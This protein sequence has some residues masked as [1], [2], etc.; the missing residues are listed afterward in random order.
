MTWPLGVFLTSEPA[1]VARRE[2]SGYS[3][4]NIERALKSLRRIAKISATQ[5][6]AR[7]VER[8]KMRHPLL[9]QLSP[10]D[11]KALAIIESSRR[12]F[13]NEQELSE[14]RRNQRRSSQKQSDRAK[15]PRKRL[16]PEQLE[17][18]QKHHAKWLAD[19]NDSDHGW[20]KHCCCDL[21]LDIDPRTLRNYL[22]H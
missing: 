4:N 19:H 10:S 17:D 5:A 13:L 7:A 8:H 2:L 9:V 14:T 12:A 15:N 18:I 22:K 6:G 3:D 1:R 20:P 21:D 11:R 16:T